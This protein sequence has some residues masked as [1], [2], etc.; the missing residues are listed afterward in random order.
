[1]KAYMQKFAQSLM[2]PISILPVA[3]LLL[4]IASFIDPGAISG[5]GN[6]VANFLA[7][8]GLAILDN[9]PI[10]FAVG[11]AFGMSKDKNGAAALSGL[12]SFLVVTNVLSTE[13]MAKTLHMPEEKVNLAFG[14]ISNVFVG[15]ICG[16]VTAAIY[17]RFKDTKLPTAFAFFSGKR[18]VPILSATAMLVISLALMFMWPPVYNALVM[19]GEFISKLGPTGAGLYGFFNRLLLPFGLHH[20]LNQ[21]FW[22]DIAGINDI[23]NFWSSKGEQGITGRYQAGLF[24]IMMFGLPAAAL[25]IWKNAEKRNKKVVGSLMLAAGLAS[26]ITGIT[27]PLEFSFLVVAPMLFVLHAVLTGISLFIAAMFHW[28]AGFTFSAGLIDYLLSLSIP[29]ANKPIMLLVLGL[30]M[31]VV[32]FF[33]FDFAIR[34]F[35]LKTPGR[36]GL[37]EEAVKQDPSLAENGEGS[38]GKDGDLNVSNKTKLIYEAIGGKDNI[39]A[40][41]HC[42]TRL[43]LT[44]NDTGIVDQEKIKKSGALGNKI[45]SDKNIQIIIGTDVQFTAD[46][47]MQ[48]EQEDR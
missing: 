31:G 46:E 22:F 37:M 14:D 42:A 8:G 33:A 18:L 27:E 9:L 20:A 25:A 43:R 10:L 5:E 40:I 34:I 3:G 16:L 45:I 38:L 4:G 15:I 24:P 39:E 47:L 29:I 36:D 6:S 1:M 7:N 13:S 17:N 21:V 44:L 35:N 28:T 32:Y 12:V 30:V 23:A 26:F 11:L 19:F 41:D 2:L 48:M